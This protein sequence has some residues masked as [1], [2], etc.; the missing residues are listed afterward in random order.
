MTTSKLKGLKANNVGE[1]LSTTQ[2]LMFIGGVVA[3]CALFLRSRTGKGN[4]SGTGSFTSLK[5]KSMA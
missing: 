4:G 3:V 2:K 5:E 1:G